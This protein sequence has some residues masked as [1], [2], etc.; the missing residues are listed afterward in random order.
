MDRALHDLRLDWL[1]AFD[2]DFGRI[3]AIFLICL[4]VVMVRCARALAEVWLN[5]RKDKRKY[6]ELVRSLQ[7]KVRER[8]KVKRSGD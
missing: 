3:V 4:T 8:T 1:S 7:E 6:D 5:D 2:T